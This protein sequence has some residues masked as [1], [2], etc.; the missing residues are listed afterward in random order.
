VQ[1]S[2]NRTLAVLGLILNALIFMGMF[3]LIALSLAAAA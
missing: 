3:L 2:R 1:S